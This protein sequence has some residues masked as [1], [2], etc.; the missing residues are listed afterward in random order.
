M[1][2]EFRKAAGMTQQELAQKIGVTN[3][4][5]GH[6]ERGIRKVE[7]D[8]LSIIA[9]VFGTS[10]DEILG[11]RKPIITETK[12]ALH[13]NSRA[14]QMKEVF[15]KLNPTDQRAVLKMAKSLSQ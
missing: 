2:K 6:Y 4:A 10:I 7:Q 12:K 1:I 11:V 15:E 14:A 5:I 3:S 8:K 9:E 13:G